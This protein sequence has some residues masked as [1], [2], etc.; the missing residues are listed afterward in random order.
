MRLSMRHSEPPSLRDGIIRGPLPHCVHLATLSDYRSPQIS[1]LGFKMM[2]PS[3]RAPGDP[4]DSEPHGVWVAWRENMQPGSQGP[5]FRSQLVPPQICA[6]GQG[7]QPIS[8]SLN[9]R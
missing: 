8:S 2:G 1:L 4:W 3:S 7:P 9:L 6:L 5:E